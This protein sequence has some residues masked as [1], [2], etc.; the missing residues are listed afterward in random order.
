MPHDDPPIIRRQACHSPERASQYLE[1]GWWR[2]ETILEVFA[3][4]VAML[5]NATAVSDP[6]NLETLCDMPAQSLTWS[7]L[8]AC[9][10]TIAAKLYAAGIRPG[11]V[12]AVLLPNSVALTAS[13]LAVWR[14]GAVASPMPMSYRRH[15]LARVLTCTRASALLTVTS[16]NNRAPAQTA[17]SL[18]NQKPYDEIRLRVVFTFGAESTDGAVTL[19]GTPAGTESRRRVRELGSELV[20]SV[21]DCITIC[22]TSGTEAAPKGVPRCHGDW[23]AIAQVAQ[24]AMAV[25]P[26]SVIVSPF[27]MVNM[28][29]LG[30]GILPWLLGGGHLVHHH[31]LDL[32]LFLTQIHRYRATHANMAPA[33]MTM[34]RNQ[35]DCRGDFDLSSLQKVGAG[36]GPLRPG[37]VR[38][39]QEKLGIDVINFFASNEGVCLIA[40]PDDIPD[41]LM[42]AHYLPNYNSAA[43][44]WI[45][46]VASRT[47]VRLVDMATGHPVTTIGGRGELRIKGP[48]I[49]AGYLDGTAPRK[50]FDDE[51]Y[52]C[53][54]DV[55][56]LSGENGEFLKFVDHAKDIIVR[57]GMNISPA[58]IEGIL[59][60][61]AAVSEVAIVGY[62]DD[63]F[64]EKCCAVV[65]PEQGATPTLQQLADYLRGRDVAS[66][67]L[68]E[69][70]VLTEA[71]P[72][73]PTGK[74]MRREL[75]R[76]VNQQ[77]H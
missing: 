50:P 44:H 39:W 15:E 25:T 59:I 45:T 63:V 66:F 41:P 60:D 27:P 24:D 54:G 49:F 64:G 20:H 43:R 14:L 5:A 9:A 40:A 47:D 19:D 77:A 46:A 12:V 36:G 61:H 51:G 31:P 28:A 4:N 42:R 23:L 35:L 76:T 7:E 3:R 16:F 18:M 53:S 69:L 71:L 67:K 2:S 10:E 52:F 8:D 13:Y 1:R 74:L 30:S 29:G 73:S 32:E 75:G 33:I 56:E 11:D 21:N 37:D 58:E 34:L 72:R 65:V 55:F 26:D 22:W 70:L 38:H 62:S 57:G 6:S 48:T 17:V 68:P